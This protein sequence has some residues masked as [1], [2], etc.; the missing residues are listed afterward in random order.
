MGCCS[1][2]VQFRIL[3]DHPAT[4]VGIQR[5]SAR[6]SLTA[7][8][9]SDRPGKPICGS[10]PAAAPLLAAQGI[11]CVHA[12]P[13]PAARQGPA[14]GQAQEQEVSGVA[15]KAAVAHTSPASHPRHACHWPQQH[16]ALTASPVLR[17]P[18]PAAS[19]TNS[20]ALPP[21]AVTLSAN[22]LPVCGG[23]K[24]GGMAGGR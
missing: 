21:A 4:G 12:W 9:A 2:C 7:A 24:R 5:G 10:R 23:G 18:C 19:Y 11:P 17:K 15:R 13:Q 22:F 16:Q 14:G 3:P 20:S 1:E 8:A 6:L